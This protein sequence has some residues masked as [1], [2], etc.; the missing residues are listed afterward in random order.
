M[1]DFLAAAMLVVVV[2]PGCML[3]QPDRA[4]TSTPAMVSETPVFLFL[5]LILDY[6]L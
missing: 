2:A 5:A 4:I 1:D 6:L 3:E